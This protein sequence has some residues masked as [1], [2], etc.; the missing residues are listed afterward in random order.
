M[1]TQKQLKD[2][3]QVVVPKK[4][5]K[6][7][8]SKFDS[9]FSE[10]SEGISFYKYAAGMAACL[11]FAFIGYFGAISTTSISNEVITVSENSS[12]Y[13]V[14]PSIY[15]SESYD[16]SEESFDYTEYILW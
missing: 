10:Q 15:E 4:F 13:S 11:V 3:T 7:F 12:E 8:W 9:E 6:E 16:D 14:M 2:K 5:D 1:S